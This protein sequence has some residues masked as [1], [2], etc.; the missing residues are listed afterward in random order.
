MKKIDE[1]S[2]ASLELELEWQSDEARH[3]ERFLARRVNLWRD[4]FPPSMHQSLLGRAPGEVVSLDYA[5]GEAIPDH[6][7]GLIHRVP[8]AQLAP[9]PFRLLNPDF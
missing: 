2:L 3:L 4:L 7:P 1:Q 5:P 9:L 6:D 8:L